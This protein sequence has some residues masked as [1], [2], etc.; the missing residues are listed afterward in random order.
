MIRGKNLNKFIQLRNKY[1]PRKIKTIFIFESP[2]V[3]KGYFY[4]ETGKSS[5]ILYRSLMK[6]LFNE[7]PED[8]SEGLKQFA[9]NGYFIINAT[10]RPINKIKDKDAD[11]YILKNYNSLKKDLENMIESKKIKIILVKKN[12]C[13]LLKNKLLYDG[14]NVVNNDEIIPFPM[15][16]HYKVFCKK[17]NKLLKINN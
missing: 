6:C 13:I 4:D 14:F 15:H 10:Y 17:I 1:I 9:E 8:K 3:D 7:V 2:P 5:E 11:I 16:Y 12:I